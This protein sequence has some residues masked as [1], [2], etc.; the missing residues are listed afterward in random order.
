LSI[1]LELELYYRYDSTVPCNVVDEI[2]RALEEYD[3]R[4]EEY[5]KQEFGLEYVSVE[6]QN[7]DSTFR[8]WEKVKKELELL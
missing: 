3:E 2:L 5:L 8:Y 6:K 4:T 1:G 7:M